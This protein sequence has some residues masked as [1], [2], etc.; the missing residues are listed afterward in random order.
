MP[1]RP[2]LFLSYSSEDRPAARTLRDA[3]EAAGLEVWYDESELG[4][5]DAWDQKIRRQI[6]E[7]R[8]FMPVISASTERRSEGYFRREWKLAVERT[9]DMADDVL[10]LVPVVIDGTGDGGARV[11]EKFLTVQWQRIPGGRPGPALDALA[12]RLLTGDSPSPPRPPPPL[13]AAPR[14][15][16]APAAPV[17]PE[18]P[19]PMPPFPVKPADHAH[20]FR[21]FAEIL[22][23]GLT[24]AWLVFKRFPRWV[25]FILV[26]ALLS[27]LFKCTSEEERAATAAKH[28]AAA[29]GANATDG[30]DEAAAADKKAALKKAVA[31]AQQQ[32]EAKG[33]DNVSVSDLM[34]AGAKLADTVATELDKEKLVAGQ[35]GV[36][37]F[38][39]G[40][41][42]ADRDT[43]DA[44]HTA[45]FGQLAL[46]RSG[47]IKPLGEASGAALD[48]ARLLTLAAKAGDERVVVARGEPGQAG[49]FL[50]VRLL[51]TSD[52]SVVWQERYALT[53]ANATALARAIS[54]AVLAAPPKA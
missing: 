45:L 49:S 34:R 39:A 22:W 12:R 20:R 28:K 36:V 53:G 43:A 1:A 24:A 46:A 2:S 4:G 17:H 16:A 9:H 11:P 33:K 42:G 50:T 23:W 7:C 19:P 13:T 48:E 41:D 5:G 14:G 30:V 44:I 6:R 15:G 3:L 29:D 32:L 27:S 35:I 37:S 10:F 25:R 54:Q 26:L 51:Q 52:G 38:G 31:E 47:L 40:L 18:G 8:F 21:Y